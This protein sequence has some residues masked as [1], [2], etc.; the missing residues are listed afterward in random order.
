MADLVKLVE[1]LRD[2]GERDGER[3]LERTTVE[4][5][6][7]RHRT[8]MLDDTF[9]MVIDWG[10]GLMV[11][12]WYYRKRPASY[13]YGD[14]AS[15][16]AFGHGGQQ[17]SLAFVDPEI[18]LAAALCCNGMPGEAANHRRTQP[19]ITALYEELGLGA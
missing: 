2:G 9:G 5:L 4:A 18:G 12:S 10:L 14:H 8:A 1:M 13:G 19:V 3:V 17:S 7:A 11:N 15:M 6:A 16:R